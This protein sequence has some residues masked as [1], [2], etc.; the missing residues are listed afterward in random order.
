MLNV[1]ALPKGMRFK[2]GAYYHINKIGKW[3]HLGKDEATAVEAAKQLSAVKYPVGTIGH[4]IERYKADVI[5]GKAPKTQKDNLTQAAQLLSYFDCMKVSRLEPGDVGAYLRER[6]KDGA[7]VLGNRERALLSHVFT[8]AMEWKLAK[9][10]PC[11]GVTR[12]PEY[13]RSRY[14]TDAEFDAVFGLGNMVVQDFMGIGI[15]TALRIGDILDIEKDDVTAGS[16]AVEEDGILVEPN[17]TMRSNPGKTMLIRMSPTMKAV[18]DRRLPHVEKYLFE[19]VQRQGMVRRQF[20][21][22]GISSMFR[23]TVKKALALGLIKNG[24]TF[25]D[26]RAKSLTDANRKGMNA[27]LLAGHSDPKMTAKYIKRREV[28]IVPAMR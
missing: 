7:P 4:L 26:I 11:L 3:T 15:A 17:K 14:I 19:Y 5:P 28:E 13:G 25:H 16:V 23:A 22:N 8:M 10:N 24:F 20:T 18:V 9:F 1:T 12:N 21:Y 27:Q 6:A 2:H